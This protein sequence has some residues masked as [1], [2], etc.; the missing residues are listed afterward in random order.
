MY[1]YIYI[2]IERERE[3]E[4][5]IKANAALTTNA[6][7]SGEMLARSTKRINLNNYNIANLNICV[8][9]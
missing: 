3:R 6:A 4:R 1:I 8:A 7:S 2:Y 9:K 5:E